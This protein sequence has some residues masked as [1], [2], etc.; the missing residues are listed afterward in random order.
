[1]MA[2]KKFV[3]KCILFIK[4]EIVHISFSENQ[5]VEFYQ[6]FNFKILRES[7]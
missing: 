1:M 6:L 3:Q 2:K 5:H 4:F 7:K